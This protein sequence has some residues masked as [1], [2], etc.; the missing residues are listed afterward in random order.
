MIA[1]H[2][3]DVS[4]QAG[5][6]IRGLT[7]G[8][9]RVNGVR[10]VVNQVD[11]TAHRGRTLG[12]VGE[13]GC[14]KSVTL[15]AI[16]GLIPWP[17]DVLEG[18]IEWHKRNLLELKPNDRRR[19]RGREIAMIFQDPSTN[20]TPVLTVGYQIAE[21]LRVRLGWDRRR[22]ANGAVELLAKVGIAAPKQRARAYPHQ[23]SGGMRQ[24]VG[25]AMA[26]A[27][28][29]QLLLADEPTTA[30]D[31]TIQDQILGLLT[32]IQQD[33]GLSLIIVSHDL[34]VIAEM[35]DEIAVMYGG[36]LVEYGSRV[37]VIDSPRHPYT[38]ALLGSVPVIDFESRRRPTLMPA[39]AAED[40]AS[41]VGC[42]FQSRCPFV[43]PDCRD[44][45]ME[46]DKAQPAH[47]S[48]CP[49]V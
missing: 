28:Q 38:Q 14:G 13:S 42:P 40:A 16:M 37:Q 4:T 44:V 12:L 35:A 25:I 15:R 43:R 20:L 3:M 46:L 32:E 34:A 23:L 45:S 8:F 41:L 48:A 9:P 27:C 31:V 2:Q 36:H 24:R 30:L 26:I 10:L 17:G 33:S 22:A 18:R 5:L 19:V 29:P 1:D 11:L 49:F 39:S 47:G 6:Q 21:I 7:V